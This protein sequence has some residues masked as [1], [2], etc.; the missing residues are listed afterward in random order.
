MSDKQGERNRKIQI[1][2]KREVE[3][4]KHTPRK[5]FKDIDVQGDRNRKI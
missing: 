3:R 4:Y 1:Y 5:K 2:R